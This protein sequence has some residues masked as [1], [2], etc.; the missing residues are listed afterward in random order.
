M[1]TNG[2]GPWRNAG[3]YY[4]NQADPVKFLELI[5]LI[6]LSDHHLK[7]STAS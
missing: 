2:R 4:M 7:L 6:R 5:G 1:A 3:A